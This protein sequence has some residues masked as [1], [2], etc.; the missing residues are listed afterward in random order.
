MFKRQNYETTPHSLC[1]EK[2]DTDTCMN[3]TLSEYTKQRKCCKLR[4]KEHIAAA[5]IR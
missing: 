4:E 5:L 1:Q 3:T 2:H